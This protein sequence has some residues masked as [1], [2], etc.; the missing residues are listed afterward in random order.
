MPRFDVGA[1]A[2]NAL[3]IHQTSTRFWILLWLRLLG[4]KLISPCG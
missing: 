4:E 2:S 3:A 1:A